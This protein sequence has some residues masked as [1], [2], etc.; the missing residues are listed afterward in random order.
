MEIIGDT[1]DHGQQAEDRCHRR[2]QNRPQARASGGDDGLPEVHPSLVEPVGV[3]DEDDGIVDH[4]PGQGD[5]PDPG[6]D[7]AKGQLHNGKAKEDPT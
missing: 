1:R 2:Q 5:D 3:M 7:D 4:Y 6:H